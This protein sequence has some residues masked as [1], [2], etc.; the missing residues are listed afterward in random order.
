MDAAG[1]GI[2]RGLALLVMADR[3]IMKDSRL[4]GIQDTLELFTGRQYFENVYISGYTDFIFGTNNTTLFNKCTIHVID[5]SKDD[6]GTAGYITAFK[7]SNK[8]ASDAIV[9]GAI[10]YDCDFT[11]DAGVSAGKTAIGR[12]WGAYAAVAV[13][14]SD[15]GGHISVDA[16]DS[17]NNKN[18]RYISMNGIH[19]TDSTVQFVEYGNTGAGA[20]T[21]AVAGMKMLTQEQAALY[22]DI[23]VIFGKTNGKVNWLD[24]WD[25]TSTEEQVDDRTYYYFNGQT[26]SSGTCYTY[27]GN[28]QGA[29]GTLG[30]IAIDATASGAKVTARSSDTQINAGATLT[31]NVSAGTLVTINFYPSYGNCDIN[32]TAYTSATDVELYFAAD[33]TVVITATATSYLYSIIINP[34]EAAPAA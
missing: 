9:Y 11:A 27:S 8:G 4:L 12:T 30:N 20:I 10:F 16:Y 31:F 17:S 22:T 19:P 29:A 23:S 1:L 25:P 6:S 15:L 21:A 7:G 13:I 26:G 28:T 33:T 14:N 3:F 18:K 34:G 5:T 24:A 32:G 2:E